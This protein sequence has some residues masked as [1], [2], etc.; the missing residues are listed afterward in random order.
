MAT[1]TL[2]FLVLI[3][4]MIMNA[5]GT[6]IYINEEIKPALEEVEIPED[7][8]LRELLGVKK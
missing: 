1:V 3:G 8:T 4:S 7:V 6:A 5:A 2:I